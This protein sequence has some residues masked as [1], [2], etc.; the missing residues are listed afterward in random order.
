VFTRFSGCTDSLTHSLT[1]GWTDP[2]TECLW[3]RFQ[4]NVT[5]LRSGLCCHRPVCLS[6][7]CNVGAPY[8][9]DWTFRQ[10]FFTAVY[11]GH[12][13]TSLHNFMEI[14]QGEPLHRRR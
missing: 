9:R 5:T 6:S 1:H 14:V 12:N 7:V 3:H 11:P 10:Y 2:Y 4:P 13:L 8:S